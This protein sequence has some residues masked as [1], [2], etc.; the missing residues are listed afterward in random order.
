[1]NKAKNYGEMGEIFGLGKEEVEGLEKGGEEGL[2][3]LVKGCVGR[4]EEIEKGEREEGE[5]GE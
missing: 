1:M 4:L 2:R 5:K 3:G